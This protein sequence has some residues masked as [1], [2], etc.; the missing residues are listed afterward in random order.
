MK[1]ICGERSLDL[2]V[3]Q[4]MGI[5]NATPD[6]FSDG[7]QFNSLENAL[8]HARLMVNQGATIIDV[9][10]E[11]TRPGAVPVPVQQELDRVIPVI[12]Q[13]RDQL[14]VCISLDSSAPEVFLEAKKA[15]A[16]MIND[17]RALQREGALSAA[18]QTG[19]PVCLMHMQGEPTN[20]QDNPCY[21][22][23]ISDVYDFFV[24]RVQACQDAGIR[25]DQIILD[26]GFGFGKTL[27]DNYTL[28]AQL[29][30]FHTLDLP[31]LIGLSRKS[32]IAGVLNN[33]PVDKRVLGSVAGAVIAAMNGAKIIRVH[34]VQETVE[35]LK[36]VQ[37]AQEQ[38]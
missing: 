10:G 38:L 27:D 33:A 1:L 29:A 16:H 25:R 17:V 2:G 34:D 3:P 19:L 24:S 22:Q 32:M 13:I 8:S 6:S 28:L 36:V 4:V 31:L 23:I 9:G 18:K 37:A 11:S 35:A 20:M 12:E 21:Q 14:D 15:G 30:R 26:P 5:L 7:G